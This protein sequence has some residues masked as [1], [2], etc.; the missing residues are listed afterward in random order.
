MKW[1]L[2]LTAG[3]LACTMPLGAESLLPT[4][5]R[6]RLEVFVPDFTADNPAEHRGLTFH[7]FEVVLTNLS[8]RSLWVTSGI[9]YEGPS[10]TQG[11]VELS[12]PSG[13][14]HRACMACGGH[15]PPY[16]VL[17]PGEQLRMKADL[18]CF[19]QLFEPGVYTITIVYS[20]SLAMRTYFNGHF[21]EGPPA[22]P[23][24]VDLLTEDIASEP[25]HFR[26]R[27]PPPPLT[28]VS[29]TK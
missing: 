26:L 18:R 16:L 17:H 11:R 23:E 7:S 5:P 27:A 2:P 6:A 1:L 8:K 19:G 15:S 28:P 22:P 14:L 29:A 13:A 21:T 9:A 4:G 24:G 3:L 20:P 10:P 12:G 25:V